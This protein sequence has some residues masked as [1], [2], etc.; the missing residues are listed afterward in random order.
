MIQKVSNQGRMG[1]MAQDDSVQR[2]SISK[3]A[4]DSFTEM[5]VAQ[6]KTL[7]SK[8]ATYEEIAAK[9]NL[10]VDTLKAMFEQVSQVK[11]ASNECCDTCETR[12]NEA[13]EKN[14]NL[15]AAEAAYEALHGKK[16][17][18]ALPE[19][20]VPSNKRVL[21]ASGGRTD[22]TDVGGPRKQLKMASS[23]SIFDVDVIDRAMETKDNGERLREQ[24]AARDAHREEIKNASRYTTI[25][26]ESLK[27]ALK[28]TDQRKDNG[29]HS[30][31]AQE[32]HK[33]SNKLPMSGMSIFD[34]GNF[35]NVGKTAGE[36]LAD[37]RKKEAEAPKE[38]TWVQDAQKR[39]ANTRDTLFGQMID[40]LLE[41]KE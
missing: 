8:G 21:S 10:G 29:I 32:A 36:E 31:S 41:G 3:S 22:V 34:S 19:D 14:Q 12:S 17:S 27:E 13:K 26:G 5:V 4:V 30:I 11:T 40:S 7:K 24:N 6:A 39:T 25:N 33:Y 2:N 28:E 20:F 9:F 18:A 37:R 15:N 35:D 16:A 23:P 1:W 38:R